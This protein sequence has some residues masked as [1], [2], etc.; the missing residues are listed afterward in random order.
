MFCPTALVTLA[1]GRVERDFLFQASWMRRHPGACILLRLSFATGLGLHC[2]AV[3]VYSLDR[4]P[5]IYYLSLAHIS[6]EL[7]DV[8]SGT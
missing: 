8:F 2:W 3:L 5:R 6:L 4:P 1:A 7:G